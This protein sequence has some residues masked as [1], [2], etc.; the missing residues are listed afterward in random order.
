[1][2]PKLIKRKPHAKTI[3]Y[4]RVSTDKQELNNQRLEILDYARKHH[5][6]VDEFL[7]IEISSRKD[8]KQRRIDELLSKLNAGDTLIVSELSRLGRSVGQVVN[9]VDELI[10]KHI[11]IIAI[12]ENIDIAA[13]GE[14]DL[15]TTVMVTMFCLFA[16]ME[17]QL[18]SERTK[19]GLNAARQQGK[20]LGRPCGIGK[21][22][23]DEHSDEIIALLRNGSTKTFVANRYNTSKVNLHHWLNKHQIDVTPI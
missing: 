14:K 21:S 11:R 9:I 17:R 18:I 3:A 13:N 15:Q 23:L 5:L 2:Q 12:K 19:Q 16:E 1:M 4:L 10:K 6:T 20:L 8:P 7:S 22:K